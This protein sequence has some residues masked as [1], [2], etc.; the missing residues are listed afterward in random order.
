MKKKEQLA[1]QFQIK[2]NQPKSHKIEQHRAIFRKKQQTNHSVH[3]PRTNTTQNQNRNRK[4]RNKL[5]LIWLNR[6]PSNDHRLHPS[7]HRCV[8]NAIENKNKTHNN[9]SMHGYSA[10]FMHT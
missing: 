2:I 8:F 4:T 6:G 9:K 3:T 10:H 7:K 1:K 5:K